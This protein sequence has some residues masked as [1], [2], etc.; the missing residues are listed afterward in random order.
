M[1]KIFFT[2][3]ALVL[4]ILTV[5]VFKHSKKAT[6]SSLYTLGILQT[7]SHPAL[8][9]VKTGFIEELDMLIGKKVEYIIYNAQGSPAQAQ[10]AAMQIHAQKQY[11]A[12]F[13]IATPAAQALSA[14]EKKRPIILAAVTDPTALGLTGPHNNIT[15]VTDMVDVTKIID[16]ITQLIPAAQKVGIVYTSGEINSVIMVKKMKAELES[17]GLIG[18]EYGMSSEADMYSVVESA[19]RNVDVLLTPTDNT[20]ASSI[21]ALASLA[22]KYKKPLI[23]TDTL[24]INAGPLAAC[25]VDYKESGKQA[26]RLA[27]GLLVH[28]Q[29]PHEL[30]FKSAESTQIFINENSLKHL[31]LTIPDTLH[32]E[33]VLVK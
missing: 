18:L 31:A 14:V 22:L 33:I 20:V 10:A 6:S 26:A 25:G 23:V 19:C 29:L 9:A 11:S 24:L 7:A 12:F 13:A 8:D 15:G 32:N 16:V 2:S 27:Y 5:I 28:T 1:K 30:A 3:A 17:R 4:L 21:T